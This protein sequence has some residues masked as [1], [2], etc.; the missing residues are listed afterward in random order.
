MSD[1]TV[2]ETDEKEYLQVKRE[3][4]ATPKKADLLPEE[5]YRGWLCVSGAFLCLFCS[6]GFLNAYVFQ[7][8]FHQ[9]RGGSD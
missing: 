4:E 6:F 7:R 3:A 1:D 2:N 5:G 8:S 9:I